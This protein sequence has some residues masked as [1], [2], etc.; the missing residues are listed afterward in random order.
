MPYTNTVKSITVKGTEIRWISS[1]IFSVQ[2]ADELIFPLV[3]LTQN[4]N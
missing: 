3:I 2:P 4:D 1:E